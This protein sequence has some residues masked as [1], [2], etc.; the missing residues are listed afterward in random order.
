MNLLTALNAF[1]LLAAPINSEEVEI[2]PVDFRVQV[3][4][5]GGYYS[6]P[7]YCPPGYYYG[8]S[9]GYRRR[10][11]SFYF[12]PGYPGYYGNRRC[13]PYHYGRRYY[14]GPRYYY[15]GGHRRHSRHGRRHHRRR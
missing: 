10:G 8:P 13:Y 3:Y 14:Y 15:R 11:F 5:Y 9:Y 1:L 7:P 6:Y 12:G 2:Q 4:P